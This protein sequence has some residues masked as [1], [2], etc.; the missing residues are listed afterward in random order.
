M[1]VN[2][3]DRVDVNVNP[4]RDLHGP[5]VIQA[6]NG[7][8]LLSHQDSNLHGGGDGFA[9]QWRS[10]DGGFT[11]S[12]E[13]PVADWR[14]RG[15]DS[16]FGEYGLA[17]DGSLVMIVQRREVLGGD[18][19]IVGSWIQVSEDDGKT[20]REVGPV[21]DSDPYAVMFA[22]N[23]VVR[24]G[25]FYAGVWSR[26]GNALYVSSDGGTS[27]TKHSLIF[28]TDYPD[29]DRLHEAGPPFYPHVEWCPDGSLLAMTYQTPPIGH[30]YSRRSLDDGHTWEPIVKETDLDIWAP[31]VNR[32]DE[33]TLILTGRDIDRHETVAVFSEDSGRTW[34]NRME[35]D[36]PPF[37][38]SYAYS[39]SVRVEGTG[40]WV[41]TSSPRSE[42][43]GDIVG[44]LLE[45]E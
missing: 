14:D 8:L 10:T 24:D 30:C 22:R 38:G 13:G 31:R 29:F 40:F 44:V 27:W 6:S 9:R 20:W 15:F 21:D 5:C 28:P 36:K 39:D 18:V 4:E 1:Q 33:Q 45:R 7:D 37:E 11:W 19:G 23:L 26:Y 3:L 12:D 2:V 34:G 16:L 41:F 32:F 17:P 35:I 42:G 25:M 43:K